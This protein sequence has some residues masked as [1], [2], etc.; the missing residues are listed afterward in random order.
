MHRVLK[1]EHFPL[2]TGQNTSFFIFFSCLRLI[3]QN[4]FT[5]LP[6]HIAKNVL[7]LV[8]CA[9]KCGRGSS[10]VNSTSRFQSCFLSILQSESCSKFFSSGIS[11]LVLLFNMQRKRETLNCN[12]DGARSHYFGSNTFSSG[13]SHIMSDFIIRIWSKVDFSTELMPLTVS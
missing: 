13:F 5:K 9:P 1:A 8:F 10:H 3:F 6:K 4:F 2:K 12:C 7:Q 11:K